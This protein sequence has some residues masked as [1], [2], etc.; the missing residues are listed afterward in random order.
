MLQRGLTEIPQQRLITTWIMKHVFSDTPQAP[1]SRMGQMVQL[2]HA[3]SINTVGPE[4]GQH[5][6]P[7]YSHLSA[8]V[9]LFIQL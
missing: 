3:Q 1:I 4:P 9:F 7:F 2:H 8:I 5:K 6:W